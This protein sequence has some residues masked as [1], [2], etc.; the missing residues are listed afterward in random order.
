MAKIIL[1][2]LRK[3][4]VLYGEKAAPQELA[5]MARAFLDADY[6][7]D[8]VQFLEGAG[9]EQSVRTLKELALKQGDAFILAACARARKELVTDEDWKALAKR[10]REL[11]KDAYAERAEHILRGGEPMGPIEQAEEETPT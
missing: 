2:S 8:A 4:H 9:D 1:D 6:P 5:A 3:R 10:A 11:G 7:G